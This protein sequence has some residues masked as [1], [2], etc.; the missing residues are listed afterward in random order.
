[1]I[2]MANPLDAFLRLHVT[3]VMTAAGFTKSGRKYWIHSPRDD[4]GV[5]EF[6]PLLEGF[7]GG[8]GVAP[9]PMTGWLERITDPAELA[10]GVRSRYYFWTDGVDV[11]GLDLQDP[12]VK[13]DYWGPLDDAEQA[14]RLGHLLT[15]VLTDTAV[16]TVRAL[17]DRSALLDLTLLDYTARPGRIVLAPRAAPLVLLVD[18]E[19]SAELDQGLAAIEAE[20]DPNG[21]AAWARGW[22]AHRAA[23]AD[24]QV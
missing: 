14:D 10:E 15:G 22:M 5:I 16:P 12:Y 19:P 23:T 17:M 9:A 18:E 8:Y 13:G 3:P 24:R 6:E 11:P 1:M 7:G 20:G 2:S 4:Y 21:F